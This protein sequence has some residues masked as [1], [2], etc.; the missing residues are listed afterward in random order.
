[1][2]QL[3]FFLSKRFLRYRDLKFKT[4]TIPYKIYF[5]HVFRQNLVLF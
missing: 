4:I 2:V 3:G 5:V 1:M